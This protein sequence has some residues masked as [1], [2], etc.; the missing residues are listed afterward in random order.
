MEN[1][2]LSWWQKTTRNVKR[3][4]NRAFGKPPNGY[5][6]DK[7]A[8]MTEMQNMDANDLHESFLNGLEDVHDLGTPANPHPDGDYTPPELPDGGDVDDFGLGDTGLDAPPAMAGEAENLGTIV[9]QIV[10]AGL[11]GDQSGRRTARH[12][13][14]SS[15][16]CSEQHPRLR[17]HLSRH[18]KRCRHDE[19]FRV[20]PELRQRSRVFPLSRRMD[21][22]EHSLIC[23]QH[24][25]ETRRNGR[26]WY[27]QVT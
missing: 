24:R 18:R 23:S 25:R 12:R 10:D 13:Y 1:I 2:P 6:F 20:C 27:S 5:T 19:P 3:L 11:G 17:C 14:C 16:G 15:A 8:V 21:A 26:S 9:D 4:W 7:S 22:R